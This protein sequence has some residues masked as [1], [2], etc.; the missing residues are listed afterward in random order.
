MS[1]GRGVSNEG[2]A[3]K[4]N[5]RLALGPELAASTLQEQ[6]DQVDVILRVVQ[7]PDTYIQLDPPQSSLSATTTDTTDTTD[8]TIEHDVRAYDPIVYLN[9]SDVI[10]FHQSACTTTTDD[11][12][13]DGDDGDLFIHVR[14]FPK[15]VVRVHPHD[16]VPAGH[17]Y[18][19]E[20]TASNLEVTNRD[21]FTFRRYDALSLSPNLRMI[22]VEIRPRPVDDEV[23]SSDDEEEIEGGGAAA[24]ATSTPASTSSSS[25]VITLDARKVQDLLVRTLFGSIVTRFERLLLF[26]P[27]NGIDLI[28]TVSETRLDQWA[29]DESQPTLV[30]DDCY[31]G[32]VRAETNICVTAQDLHAVTY[33][34]AHPIPIPDTQDDE[35]MSLCVTVS[36]T[37]DE[38][39]FVVRRRLLSPCISLTRWVM[40]G[41]GTKY[42]DVLLQEKAVVS[43]V[44]ALA[45]DRVLLYLESEMKG[46]GNEHEFDLEYTQEMLSAANK[47]GISGLV[48]LCLKKLGEFESR[49][50]KKY[51]RWEEVVRRNG[52]GG[53]LAPR[54]PGE[55]EKETLLLIGGS[56]YD[57]TR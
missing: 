33:Q 38:E 54:L 27:D 6:K 11:S 10:T 17:V 16:R 50:R 40:A 31:R 29:D 32:Y 37:D 35:M 14:S 42:K 48:D 19:S 57:V 51:I 13:D 30:P 45:F 56:I 53:S 5:Q 20:M 1:W 23:M 8:A 12:D 4:R 34:V 52:N 21:Q 2:E 3:L 55:K 18:M 39:E 15:M 9:P 36:V 43:G 25:S 7:H 44:G 22:H 28:A 41:R 26:D 47:L 24:V 46:N 49:V